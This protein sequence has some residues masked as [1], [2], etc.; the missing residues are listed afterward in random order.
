MLTMLMLNVMCKCFQNV[1]IESDLPT[2]V[3]MR[4]SRVSPLERCNVPLYTLPVT[5]KTFK[6]VQRIVML[7]YYTISAFLQQVLTTYC[8][9]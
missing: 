3:F 8:T 5:K 7:Y 6:L 9:R 4:V 1:Y 2:T